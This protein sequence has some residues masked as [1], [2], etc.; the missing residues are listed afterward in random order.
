MNVND[1]PRHDRNLGLHCRI[2]GQKSRDAF[3]RQTTNLTE[4]QHIVALGISVSRYLQKLE[5]LGKQS[6][7][8]FL[9]SLADN[10]ISQKAE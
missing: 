8:N 7:D 9:T 5:F 6:T 10:F 2:S 1:K 3:L 4:Q